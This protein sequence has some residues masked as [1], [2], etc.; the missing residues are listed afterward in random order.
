MKKYGYE[1]I[2]QPLLI[3]FKMLENEGVIVTLPSGIKKRYTGSIFTISADNL[4]SHDIGGFRR[5]F[6]SGKICRICLCDYR[7]M[8]AKS[9]ESMF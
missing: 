5:C 6:S 8:V 7:D 9:N 3:D 2:F 4:G 1:I